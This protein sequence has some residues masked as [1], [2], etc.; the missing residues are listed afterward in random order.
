MGARNAFTQGAHLDLEAFDLSSHEDSASSS[1][2]YGAVI[3]SLGNLNQGGGML[4]N[5]TISHTH[6]GERYSNIR[7]SA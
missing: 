4:F 2:D 7:V 1:V 3:G 6:K 5:G